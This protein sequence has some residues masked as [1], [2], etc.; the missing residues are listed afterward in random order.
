LLK[1]TMTILERSPFRP[2]G[3]TSIAAWTAI[4]PSSAGR[5]RAPLYAEFK[6]RI[7]AVL[8]ASNIDEARTRLGDLVAERKRFKGTGRVDTLRALER[9]FDLYT[10]HHLTPGLPADNN[11]TENV[12]KQL[13]KKL[14]LME[15]FPECRVRGTLRAIARRLL[16]LQALHRFMS[17]NQQRQGSL[18]TRR[19]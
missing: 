7:R 13:N 11:V 14:R 5:K 16:P 3:C 18:G 2:V 1:R 9:S 8:Y 15:G 19:C 6:D 17:Q 12:I 4:F 10:A